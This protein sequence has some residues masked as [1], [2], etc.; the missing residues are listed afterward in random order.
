MNI[1]VVGAG[2]YVT[3]RG[4]P[5]LGTVLPAL[6]QIS[7]KVAIGRII[8]VATRS[9]NAALVQG[10]AYRINQILGTAVQ[11]EYRTIQGSLI[12]TI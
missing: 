12:E 8:V 9:E 5:G 6:A 1:L 10:V 11:V 3:G 7:R 4:T 2:M